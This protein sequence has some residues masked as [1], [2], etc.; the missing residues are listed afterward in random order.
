MSAAHKGHRPSLEARAKIGAA[1]KNRKYS[2]ETRAK[3]SNAGKGR[4][5]TLEVRAKMSIAAA[6]RHSEGGIPGRYCQTRPERIL[7]LFLHEA[8]FRVIAQKRFGRYVVDAWIPDYNL[9]FECDGQYW[10]EYHEIKNPGYQAR[11][12]QALAE[13]GQVVV[14]FSDSE[15]LA[16]S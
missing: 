8:G 15:L 5:H 9:V 10:H 7:L 12:D 14:H 11:R 13:A 16:S 4:K 1:N 2:L 6:K 3:L